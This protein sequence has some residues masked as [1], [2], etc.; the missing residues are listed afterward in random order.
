MELEHSVSVLTLLPREKA[1]GRREV[2]G[3]GGRGGSKKGRRRRKKRR[4][5]EGG[6]R[7][8]GGGRREEGGGGGGRRRRREGERKKERG[9]RREKRGGKLRGT[10]VLGPNGQYASLKSQLAVSNIIM[11]CSPQKKF[12]VMSGGRGREKSLGNFLEN[13]EVCGYACQP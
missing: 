8:E 4:E 11:Q 13:L 5:E 12:E 7:E 10:E 6:R 3:G 2:G 9:E 1:G